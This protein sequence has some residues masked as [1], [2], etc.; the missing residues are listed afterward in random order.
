MLSHQAR[1]APLVILGTGYAGRVVYHQALMLRRIVLAASRRPET[2]LADL[3]LDQR[4]VFDLNRRDT[5]AA[6]PSGADV[7]WTFPAVP[8][9]SVAAFGRQVGTRMRR[10]IVLG[11][12][13][14]Y[15]NAPHTARGDLIDETCPVDLSI[16]RVQGEEYLR[17]TYGAIILRVA[18]IYGP[19]RN[20]LDWIRQGQVGSSDRFVNLIHVGD[21]AAICLRALER[22]VPGESYNVSDGT[23]R[24]W[25][26]IIA[27]A[28]SR[29][30]M[31]RPAPDGRSGLGKRLDTRKLQGGLGY[32]I[33]YPDLSTALDELELNES[34]PP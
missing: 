11:S 4:F 19:K 2:N 18:G 5:W 23:P 16:P 8:L 29:R 17:T 28:V 12:T 10:L 1:N 22:G 34:G 3:P 20:P 26:E 31:S 7:V 9:D 27:F 15:D 32:R 25:S 13:S 14:A 21:L 24:R 30:G 6:I 33:R